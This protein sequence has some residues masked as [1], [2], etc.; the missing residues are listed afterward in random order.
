MRMM[1]THWASTR[2]LTWQGAS[3]AGFVGRATAGAT[4]YVASSNGDP[5]AKEFFFLRK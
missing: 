2:H 3:A 4:L 1:A 5:S